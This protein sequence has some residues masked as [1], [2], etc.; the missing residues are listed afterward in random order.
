MIHNITT[1]SSR[2]E[3]KWRHLQIFFLRRSPQESHETFL[4]AHKKLQL[5]SQIVLDKVDI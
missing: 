5:M 4:E 1:V 2:F 3:V